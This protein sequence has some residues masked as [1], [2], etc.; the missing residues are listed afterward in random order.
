MRCF[1]LIWAIVLILASPVRAQEVFGLTAFMT[2]EQIKAAGVTLVAT[3]DPHVFRTTKLPKSHPDV[4]L[5]SLIIYKNKLHKV[6]ATSQ[7]IHDTGWGYNTKAKFEMLSKAL[8][9]KYGPAT[10]THDFLIRGSIWNEPRDWLAGLRKGERH[11]TTFWKMEN[12]SI[13]MEAGSHRIE[14]GY[15]SLSYEFGDYKQISA[16]MMRADNSSL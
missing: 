1:M 3:S 5:Y 16:E 15:I 8:T 4:E 9:E 14:R 13:G 7:D 2:K 6:V 10:D 12:L 11:L